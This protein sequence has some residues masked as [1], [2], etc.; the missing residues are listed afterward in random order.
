MIE[1]KSLQNAFDN[2]FIFFRAV[3]ETCKILTHDDIILL[4]SG[5]QYDDGTTGKLLLYLYF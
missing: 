1:L 5:A 3:P 4:D 2:M